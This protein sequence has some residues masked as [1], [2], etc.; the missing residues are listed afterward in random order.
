MTSE[1]LSVDHALSLG[2]EAR[3]RRVARLLTQQELASIV[4]VSQKEVDL[5]ENNQPVL[6]AVARKLLR[7]L[8]IS[9]P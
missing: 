6:P 2:F 8:G 9:T 1:V 7:H 4:G 3:V 5:L